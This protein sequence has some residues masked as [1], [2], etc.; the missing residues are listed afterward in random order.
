MDR[1]AASIGQVDGVPVMTL[2]QFRVQA[3]TVAIIGLMLSEQAYEVLEKELYSAGAEKVLNGY[4]LTTEDMFSSEDTGILNQPE[5]QRRIRHIYEELADDESRRCYLQSLDCHK[6]N[7]YSDAKISSGLVQYLD[8]DIP[9]QKGYASFVDCGA[10]TGDT[11]AEMNRLQLPVH[12]YFAFEPDLSNYQKLS[13]IFE[14]NVDHLQL[15]K[16]QLFPL[17]VSDETAIARFHQQGAGNSALDNEGEVI[18]PTVRIDD[19]MKRETVS[20][21]KMDI[22]GAELAAL[23]GAEQLISEQK[24]DLAIC[25][26]HKLSDLWDIPEYIYRLVPEYRF[27]IRCH[28]ACALETVLYATM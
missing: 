18:V 24:P 2:E 15:E 4:E 9:L 27:Y 13:S 26:Y 28:Y 25:I 16:A 17:A 19:L 3:N 6:R 7:Y 21:L 14:N 22:E 20:F 5:M 11:L 8:V 12:S 1:N 10:F 23:H